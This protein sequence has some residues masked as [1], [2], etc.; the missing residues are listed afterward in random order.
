MDTKQPLNSRP[1]FSNTISLETWSGSKIW[2]KGYILR[3]VNNSNSNI[4]LDSVIPIAVFYDPK[5]EKILD[6]LLPPEIRKEYIENPN[7]FQTIP[8]DENFPN[9]DSW[10]NSNELKEDTPNFTNTQPDDSFSWGNE[11]PVLNWGNT[12]G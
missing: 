8:T 6:N 4:P 11:S 1:D 3:Q 2:K 10:G 12:E 7:N 9:M 5:T